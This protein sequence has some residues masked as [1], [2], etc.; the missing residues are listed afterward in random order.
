M[1]MR[2]VQLGQR[3]RLKSK[4]ELYYGADKHGK[5]FAYAPAG[6]VGVVGAVN[7][8]PVC[9]RRP[10]FCCV[11]FASD[12]CDFNYAADLF[13]WQARIIEQAVSQWRAA[14]RPTEF[15]PA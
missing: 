15:E 5:V 13:P 7:V 2:D 3:V 1:K 14:V 6:A 4:H 11:D 12:E 10:N 9:G 8:P